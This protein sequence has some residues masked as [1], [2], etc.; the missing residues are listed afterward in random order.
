MKAAGR[1]FTLV[2]LLIVMAIIS[3]LFA[4]LMPVLE[5]AQESAHGIYCANNEKQLGVVGAMY[6]DEYAD[7]VLPYKAHG[8]MLEDSANQTGARVWYR[9]ITVQGFGQRTWTKGYP[10]LICPS[11]SRQI[12]TYG[13]AN[14]KIT[15]YAY[16]IRFGNADNSTASEFLSGC[17]GTKQ[18][19]VARPSERSLIMDG[20]NVTPI[21]TPTTGQSCGYTYSNANWGY[22]IDWRHNRRMNVAFLDSHVAPKAWAELPDTAYLWWK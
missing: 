11:D 5:Q 19:N 7:W 13:S 14:T 3:V 1:K 21:C 17:P 18:T 20:E 12:Y 10:S 4:M 8:A 9:Q 15:N 6:V 22:G 16:N 2:E